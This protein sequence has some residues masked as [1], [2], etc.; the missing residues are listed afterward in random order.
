MDPLE[1]PTTL[2]KRTGKTP[3]SRSRTGF[4][5]DEVLSVTEATSCQRASDNQTLQPEHDL[6]RPAV[7]LQFQEKSRKSMPKDMICQT[8]NQRKAC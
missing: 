5:Q 2:Y 8:K 3:F 4:S 1:A 7:L 6:L